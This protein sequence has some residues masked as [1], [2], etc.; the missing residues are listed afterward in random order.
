M[1][2][3]S[4]KNLLNPASKRPRSPSLDDSDAAPSKRPSRALEHE[5]GEMFDTVV[6]NV[7]NAIEVAIACTSSI[8]I[9]SQVLPPLQA[10]VKRIAEARENTH[11]KRKV[12]I[13]IEDLV[14]SI[15]SIGNDV[16]SCA[17]GL[18][19]TVQ[20]TGSD[21]FSSGMDDIVATL[22]D[23]T[24]SINERPKRGPLGRVI[25]SAQDSDFLATVRRRISAIRNDLEIQDRSGSRKIMIEIMRDTRIQTQLRQYKDDQKALET[26]H[27]ANAS[28]K[29]Y[30]TEEKARLQQGTRSKILRDLTAWARS[31][32]EEGRVYVL[33]GPAGMGKSSIAHALCQ[34]LADT[35]LGA[36]FFFIRGQISDPYSLFSSLAYQLAHSIP[37]L[38]HIVANAVR[39]SLLGGSSQRLKH[40]MKDLVEGPLRSV[41]AKLDRPI[42]LVVD[43]ID[44]CLD[45]E[46]SIVSQML[47]LLCELG[48]K[49]SSIRILLA[50]RPE[51]HILSAFRSSDHLHVITWRDL[52]KEPD[53]DR[54]IHLFIES[55]FRKCKK[56]GRFALAEDSDALDALTRLSDGLF[57]YAST[58]VKFLS[59]HIHLAAERYKVLLESQ[60]RL[61]SGKAYQKLDMLYTLILENAFRDVRDDGKHMSHVKDI[62]DWLVLFDPVGIERDPPDAAFFETVGIPASKTLDS[63]DRLRSVLIVDGTITPSTPIR[64]CHASFPQFLMDP[65]RCTD[66][67]FLVD[68]PSGH[69]LIVISLLDLLARDDVDS[70]RDADGDMPPMWEYARHYWDKHLVQARYTPELGQS[71][72]GF[73]ETHLED[74]LRLVEPWGASDW[75]K[76]L[77]TNYCAKVR[78]WYEENGPDDGLVPMLDE[79][80]DRRVKEIAAEANQ[81]PGT[82]DWNWGHIKAW[83]MDRYPRE[84]EQASVSN[85]RTKHP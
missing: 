17:S 62:L 24:L 6:S 33:H 41:V 25:C 44:E 18:A 49:Q 43:G 65:A 36:S 37:E 11:E 40:Q 72:R 39:H 82:F 23:L 63:L 5:S 38:R 85:S 22:K 77:M 14:K 26:L 48:S 81:L 59:E 70:L 16:L 51:P 29:S 9:V 35:H 1:N 47:Q 74:W 56:A 50:S 68:P 34:Q 58:I 10:L 73:V 30:L 69:A 52:H 19:E 4:I 45:D 60:G 27:P 54:D 2:R 7:Q 13:E 55:E 71:L 75:H 15:Q 21:S 8:P 46:N 12:L 28:Y 20:T 42:L 84:A 3:I 32:N 78:N 61:G 66:P 76:A 83:V 53:V 79:I 67:A 57:I 80:L 31:E 64:A